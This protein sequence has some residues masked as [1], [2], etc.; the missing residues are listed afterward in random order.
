MK[1]Q[2]HK[3]KISYASTVLTVLFWI[4]IIIL[5]PSEGETLV[6]VPLSLVLLASSLLIK[7]RV[8]FAIIIIY[9]ILFLMLTWYRIWY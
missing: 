9:V 7:N 5:S 1:L 6:Y 4:A 3:D 2:L 8:K